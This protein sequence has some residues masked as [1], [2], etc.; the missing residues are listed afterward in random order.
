MT[1]GEGDVQRWRWK[2]REGGRKGV[3]AKS[4]QAWGW[5]NPRRA[6]ERSPLRRTPGK[7]SSALLL[8]AGS[9][10]CVPC[11]LSL[12]VHMWRQHCWDPASPK[13]KCLTCTVVQGQDNF[14]WVDEVTALRWLW[15]VILGLHFYLPTLLTLPP[16]PCYLERTCI[17][18]YTK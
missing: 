17:Y 3:G 11:S 12:Q 10:D 8:L 16:Y 6:A 5:E 13:Q 9:A 18:I 7:P 14:N 1:R 2:A 15:K 4:W